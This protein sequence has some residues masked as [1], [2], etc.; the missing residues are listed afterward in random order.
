MQQQLKLIKNLLETRKA[1]RKV[2]EPENKF[3][4]PVEKVRN[5]FR[6]F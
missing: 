6:T 3:S 4:V 1:R 2:A 5:E